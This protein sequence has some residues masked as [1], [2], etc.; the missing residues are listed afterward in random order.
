MSEKVAWGYVRLSQEGRDLSLEKQKADIREYAKDHDLDLQ[1]TRNDGE[2]TSGF[3]KSREGYQL[4]REKIRNEEID[5]V[6]VRDRARLSRDFD[7]R[8]QLL[9]EFRQSGVELHVIEDGGYVDLQDVQNAGIECLHAMMGHIKKMAEITRSRD[10][11]EERHD[12]GC[13]HGKPPMGLKFADDKCHL[14]KDPDEWQQLVQII[15]RRNSGDTLVDVA[16]SIGVS[17]ATVSRVTDR[18]L[19][20]YQEK[21]AEYGLEDSPT[22]IDG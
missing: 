19:D 1:T 5:A 22:P 11:V 3:D 16:N 6:I 13:Y 17:T 14:V 21:L 8:L 7:D 2:G 10:A 4:L 20:W 18:G 12:D 15:D 9:T